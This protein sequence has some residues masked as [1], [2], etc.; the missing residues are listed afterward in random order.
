VAAARLTAQ[1]GRSQHGFD[2]GAGA[3][4][5][6]VGDSGGPAGV[7]AEGVQPQARAG[8]TP[9]ITVETASSRHTNDR[10]RHRVGMKASY[11]RSVIAVNSIRRSAGK[12][13][14]TP[15]QSELFVCDPQ[16]RIG[17][18]CG[19]VF[20]V[21]VETGLR[22][23][24][25]ARI[26]VGTIPQVSS[27][28][29]VGGVRVIRIVTILVAVQALLPPGMCPCQFV[30]FTAAPL[31]AH[32]TT[33]AS[34]PLAA[35]VDESCCSCPACRS[36]APVAP[37]AA[38]EPAATDREAPH[39]RHPTPASPCSGCPV[40]S[41]GPVARVVILLAPEQAPLDTTVNF[42]VS[43]VES[44][45]PRADR[46]NPLFAPVTPPLFVRH[47]ALLI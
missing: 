3:T 17:T 4:E 44:A 29:V 33:P 19:P 40:V 32:E 30:P 34:L 16:V 46:L 13:A 21:P 7:R 42:V 1:Q 8:V 47:C 9:P 28:R 24:S 2:V 23:L 12:V 6:C 27:S 15:L 18:C 35:H 37:S 10:T 11:T 41:A 5:G 22:T 36:V 14:R 43:T 38:E 45:A 31:A 25:T 20:R 39:E 26:P